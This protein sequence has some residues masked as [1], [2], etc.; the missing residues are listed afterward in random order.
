MLILE[1]DE[2]P[3]IAETLFSVE[4]KVALL[5]GKIH[6]DMIISITNNTRP[7]TKKLDND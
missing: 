5:P 6:P 7:H 4:I 2:S 3:E 1:R